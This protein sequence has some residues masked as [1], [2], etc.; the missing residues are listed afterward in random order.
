MHDKRMEGGNVLAFN[1][2]VQV[3]FGR[4][5]HARPNIELPELFRNG[6]DICAGVLA[7][8]AKLVEASEHRHLER[9]VRLDS[10]D[11]RDVGCVQRGAPEFC[12]CG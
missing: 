5:D 9:E 10:Q 6:I 1:T 2:E 8:E 4:W 3:M 7:S 11:G 12:H